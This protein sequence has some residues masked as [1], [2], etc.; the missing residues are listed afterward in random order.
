MCNCFQL[1]SANPST[2]NWRGIFIAL[3]VIIIVLALIITSVVV[4]TPPED[5]KST[6]GNLLDFS[7]QHVAR[8][9]PAGEGTPH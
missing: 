2:R 7:F 1:V 5:G 3:F 6:L 8:Y 4:L 9:R